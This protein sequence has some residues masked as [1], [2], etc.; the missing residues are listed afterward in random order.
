MHALTTTTSPT[1]GSLQSEP[2][3]E[4]LEFST[5]AASSCDMPIS[6]WTY[7]T[8]AY[9]FTGLSEV[10][11]LQK[12]GK[13]SLQGVVQR[14]KTICRVGVFETQLERFKSWGTDLQMWR[15][16]EPEEGNNSKWLYHIVIVEPRAT[17]FGV[18]K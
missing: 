13:H 10:Q 18:D 7:R 17:V 6:S 1:A 3:E 4:K 11:K 14:F 2:G 5:S 8:D 15:F 16:L 9:C 12:D